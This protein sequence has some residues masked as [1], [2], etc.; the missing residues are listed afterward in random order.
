MG[1]EDSLQ[2]TSNG[3]NMLA[4]RSSA[5]IGNLAVIRYKANQP[6]I[7]YKGDLAVARYK[8]DL[9]VA[10]YKETPAVTRY[11]Q[12]TTNICQA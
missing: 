1:R 9:A 6:D 7:R 10:R 4:V 11:E 12:V 2:D 3:N 8:G 5:T